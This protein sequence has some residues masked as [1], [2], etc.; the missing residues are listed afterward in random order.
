M[1]PELL[2][3]I[4]LSIQIVQFLENAENRIGARDTTLNEEAMVDL[5][6]HFLK[7]VFVAMMTYAYDW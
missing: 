3:Y 4:A 1:D 2:C 7:A 5:F 6:L